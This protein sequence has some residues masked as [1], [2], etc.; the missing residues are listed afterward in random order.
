MYAFDE[1]A[2]MLEKQCRELELPLPSTEELKV[3]YSNYQT[4]VDCIKQ[5][6]NQLISVAQFNQMALYQEASGYYVAGKH[7]LGKA[8]DFITAPE[9]SSVFTKA[10]AQVI[11]PTLSDVNGVVVEFGAGNG[12]MAEGMIGALGEKLNH[13]IILEVSPALRAAQQERLK[14]L[15]N[16]GNPQVSW[17]Q[18][19]SE[20]P[21]QAVFVANE[22][23]DAIPSHFFRVD[24][25]EF[26]EL[27]IGLSDNEFVPLWQPVF[28]QS[29]QCWLK[30]HADKNDW[31]PGCV[32]EASPWR[33]DWFKSIAGCTTRAAFV[34]TDYGYSS[35]EFYHPQRLHGSLSCFFRHRLHDKFY[36]LTGLQDITSHV[37]FS[38]LSFAA[39]ECDLDISGFTSQAQMILQSGV[40]EQ[41]D[42]S[43]NLTERLKVSQAIQK[44]MMPGEM[45]ESVKAIA[46]TRG[47]SENALPRISSELIPRL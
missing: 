25:S 32:Y 47:I 41:L 13:Y 46:F 9:I 40:L 4:I 45:G 26:Q 29:L 42:L 18:E 11:L 28:S 21:Q 20:L 12:V 34:F 43:K 39:T 15:E 23:L 35:E 14:F 2:L 31:Q 8:G 33:T 17:I 37:N 38:E 36:Y 1:Y 44:L 22:V 6:N 3:G 16:E 19:T 30:Q 27:A 24:N 5:S 7:V 10:L